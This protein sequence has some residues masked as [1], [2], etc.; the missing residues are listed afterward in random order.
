MTVCNLQQQ[1]IINFEYIR[2]DF[3]FGGVAIKRK[4]SGN[5]LEIQGETKPTKKTSSLTETRRITMYPVTA[6]KVNAIQ[7]S[8]ALS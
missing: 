8:E 5:M 6:Q 7:M 1:E 3:L 4:N 2:P